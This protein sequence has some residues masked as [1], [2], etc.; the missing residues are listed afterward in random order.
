[1]S[2]FPLA[3]IS[4]I[5]G[6][7]LGPS[8][9]DPP[10]SSSTVPV[11]TMVGR[12]TGATPPA[13]AP[14]PR[15]TDELLTQLQTLGQALHHL[16]QTV[17]DSAKGSLDSVTPDLD[18]AGLPPMPT[19]GWRFSGVNWGTVATHSSAVAAAFTQAHLLPQDYLRLQ[20]AV[21]SADLA[22]KILGSLNQS[23]LADTTFPIV[24][25]TTTM[26]EKNVEFMH[27][28]QALRKTLMKNFNL[29]WKPIIPPGAQIMNGNTPLPP[30]SMIV[31]IN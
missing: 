25:D 17:Q 10:P 19:N 28:H 24:M 21:I 16:P 23:A 1:M 12:D 26:L 4:L 3:A 20:T 11:S 31:P 9:L 15:L 27:M 2:L 7:R 30:G 6:M 8:R 29:F 14:L 18:I 5:F 13:A 22:L